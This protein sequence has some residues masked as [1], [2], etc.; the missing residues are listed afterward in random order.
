MQTLVYG[1]LGM[2]ICV[3]QSKQPVSTLFF[4]LFQLQY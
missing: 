1:G 4:F 3:F 2:P